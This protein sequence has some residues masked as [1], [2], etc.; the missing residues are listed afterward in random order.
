MQP[1]IHMSHRGALETMK[2]PVCW[3]DLRLRLLE[4]RSVKPRAGGRPDGSCGILENC[5]NT[6]DDPILKSTST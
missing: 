6:V 5:Y 2:S 3:A 4:C 1:L